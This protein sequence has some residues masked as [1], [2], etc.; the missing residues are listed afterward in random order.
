[1]S[2]LSSFIVGTF[3]GPDLLGNPA[4]ICIADTALHD[5]VMRQ[6]SI[7]FTDV[8]TATAFIWPED[9]AYRIRSFSM[10]G[11]IKFCG[12]ASL[13]AGAV[14]FSQLKQ[15]PTDIKLR[16]SHL[17]ITV[18]SNSDKVVLCLPAFSYQTVAMASSPFSRLQGQGIEALYYG[19]ETF[20]MRLSSK[21]D[22]LNFKPDIPYLVEK[23]LYLAVTAEGDLCDF[24]SR[25]FGPLSGQEED[26]VTGSAHCVLAPIWADILRKRTFIARQ[27]S[28]RG[29]QL[30]IELG[31]DRSSLT[32]SGQVGIKNK[33]TI[34]L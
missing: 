26:P 23:R 6:I 24:V 31:E 16:T 1:M 13:A 34:D 28:S 2:K 21:E 7:N 33:I 15:N 5:D 32:L 22:V 14:I 9:K 8:A 4:L 19:N 10:G 12:H 30:E 25:F 27:I 29:G 11:E 17:N 18:S 20:F 3:T